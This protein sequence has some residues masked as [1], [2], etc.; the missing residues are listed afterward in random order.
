MILNRREEMGKSEGRRNWGPIWE[1]PP[2]FGK[3]V[4]T[5]S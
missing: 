4:R 2:A 1:A 5:D 3:E